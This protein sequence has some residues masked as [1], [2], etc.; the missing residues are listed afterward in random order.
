MISNNIVLFITFLYA[1]TAIIGIWGYYPTLKDLIKDK[2]LSANHKTYM[3]WTLEY[4]IAVL[5]IGL[6]TKDLL[7][8]LVLF[9]N[10]SICLL[11]AVLS[12][13]LKRANDKQ[14]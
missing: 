11:I 13:N 10:L 14:T 2:I 9:V 12:W 4:F 8:T 3:L 6:I 5:Y 7:L 1:C